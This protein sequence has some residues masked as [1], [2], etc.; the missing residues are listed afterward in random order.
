MKR[1]LRYVK[2]TTDLGLHYSSSKDAKLKAYS[3]SDWA[4]SVD[5]MK[6]TTG[7][8]FLLGSN[9]FS[10]C[11]KKQTVVAQSTAEAEY[12]AAASTVNQV[13]WFKKIML[14][15]KM[16]QE[17]PME[18]FCDNQ[19]TIAMI[20]NPI[21]HG[22]TKHF[23]IRFHVI[24]E[25]ESEG[26]VQVLFYSSEMQLADL[27][28][29]PLPKNSMNQL[30]RDEYVCIDTDDDEEEEEEEDVGTCGNGGKER[31]KARKEDEREGVADHTFGK[32]Y[33]SSSD[34]D[35]EVGEEGRSKD[36]D[37]NYDPDDVEVLAVSSDDDEEGRRMVEPDGSE[38]HF[39]LNRIK[40]I[41]GV[42]GAYRHK[43]PGRIITATAHNRPRST[44]D[45]ERMWGNKRGSKENPETDEE[46][47]D[48][49]FVGERDFSHKARIQVNEKKDLPES[50]RGA[51]KRRKLPR[52]LEDDDVAKILADSLLGKAAIPTMEEEEQPK[53]P[54]IQRQLPFWVQ[55]TK[56]PEKTTEEKE[57][58]ALW[59]EFYFV[60]YGIG[61]DDD[62]DTKQAKVN[63]S[64]P[65]QTRSSL[66]RQGNHELTLDEE[67]GVICKH[68]LYVHVEIKYYVPPFEE[69]PS[70]F[71]PG[72]V[73]NIIPGI[74][75]GMHDHQREGFE[76]LWKNLAGGIYVDYSY[77]GS[78]CIISHAPGTGK[79]RLTIAFLQT[80]MKLY[81]TCRP[82][83]VAPSG[84]LLS[85]EGEFQKWNF[86]IPFHNLN[87]PGIT[88]KE[89]KAA[90][91][92]FSQVRGGNR[93]T[94]Q[95]SIRMVK[96][97]SWRND[98][99]VLGLSYKLFEELVG[100]G[101]K[102]KQKFGSGSEDVQVARVL[103]ENSGLLILDEGHTPRNDNS[104]IWKALSKFRTRKRVILSGTPFQNNFEEL[105]NTLSLAN[106]NFAEM[107][108]SKQSGE[109]SSKRTR[110]RDEGREHWGS[111]TSPIGKFDDDRQRNEKLEKVR[112]II[113][114]FV[115]VHRG[116][117]LQKRLPGL[118]DSV[119]ILQPDHFQKTLLDL[120]PETP[121]NSF[122]GEAM[123]TAVDL[124]NLSPSTALDGDVPD[125]VWSGKNVS[126]KHLKSFDKDRPH[127]EWDKLK[128]LELSPEAGVKTKFVLELMRFSDA[129]IEKV[130]VF[131]QLLA[132]LELIIKQL[133]WRFKWRKGTEVLY[134]DGQLEA[135]NRQALIK[136]FNDPRSESKLLLASTRACSEGINLVG[137]SRV[138][139][140]DVVWN[141][142]VER[143]AISRAYRLGQEKIVYEKYCRQVG[144][145][146]L[147]ELVFYSSEQPGQ[148]LPDTSAEDEI[149][150]N[151]KDVILE[152]MLEVNV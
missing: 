13:V 47:D 87:K 76:F 143:Q 123:R 74:G 94:C 135:A 146:R 73:W 51:D 129:R 138:V 149:L 111:L 144:K 88:G 132:H 71:P 61:K 110:K 118:R 36:G 85:W 55:E 134:M 57:I 126:Y 23:K 108:S 99:S 67:I 137:A 9:V 34:D 49:V 65:G 31:A 70:L 152:E 141:P 45:N 115:H 37:G 139:L 54:V 89:N 5:D 98:S 91:K 38:A 81:P 125:R 42:Q 2:G 104:L 112:Q 30:Q 28:T 11:S 63:N 59:A 56:P 107:I 82:V 106:P 75:K 130:L 84:M 40:T 4:E 96:L 60:L 124:I 120:I 50:S 102:K 46:D 100:E 131:S 27:F 52:D 69:D 122:W 142:S 16:E 77:T 83:I 147:S 41:G 113:S 97:Y 95:H 92:L 72:T 10:W 22:R 25:A 8:V 105:F 12:L 3:D 6:S 18:L 101:K 62:S 140:L 151:R 119:V 66:C 15:V 20:K 68:C 21:D 53:K 116:D 145:E 35:V 127:F 7:Y 109:Q 86:D 117:I 32:S 64:E 79:T 39:V 26:E 90:L 48:L 14:D 44:M 103:L 121:N 80:Y 58:E 19:S 33:I 29:K 114:R 148:Q 17:E 43:F 24:R 150:E 133:N 128:E 93:H 136:N 1:V 78:V